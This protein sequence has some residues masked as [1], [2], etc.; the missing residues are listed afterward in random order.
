MPRHRTSRDLLVHMNGE[1]VGTW[2]ITRTGE[3]SFRYD[4]RWLARSHRRPISLSMPFGAPDETHRG[5][6][7]AS[8]FENLLPDSQTIRNRIQSRYRLASSS[9][10]DLLEA[11]GR[12]CVGAIQLTPP[13]TE[14]ADVRTIAGN[15]LRPSQ[16]AALLRSVTTD[17]PFGQTM[18][19]EFRIS[20]SG[21]QEKTALLRHRGRWMQPIGPTPTT[22]ILKLP[23]GIIGHGEIDLRLSLE[24][25]WLCAQIIAAYGLPVATCEILAFD[26]QRVLAVERFDRRLSADRS[27]IMRLPQEDM[28]QA[29]GLPPAMKYETDGGPG[30]IRIMDLLLGSRQADD[31]RRTFFSAQILFWMLAAIDGHAKNFSLRLEEMGSYRFAP[32]YDV[33]SAH[34]HFSR[35]RGKLP[36]RKVRMVMAV[37]GKNR[38]YEWSGIRR[39]HWVETAQRCG[40]SMSADDVIDALVVRTPIVLDQVNRALPTDFPAD[41]ADPIFEGLRSAAKRLGA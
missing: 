15:P 21:A 31:D 29:F 26:D 41:I 33:L 7:V 8:F 28:C 3:H 11:V 2:S 32:L 38:H 34:P 23:I 12:D 20:L 25:E 6:R 9:A 10:F 39:R 5:A 13:D 18:G 17:Q 14:P 19:E 24:N 1:L 16:I 35:G 27:W 40:L 30:I 36:A 37:T 22:H 4:N